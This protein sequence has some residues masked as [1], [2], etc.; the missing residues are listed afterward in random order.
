MT[1]MKTKLRLEGSEGRLVLEDSVPKHLHGEEVN[2]IIKR[3]VTIKFSLIIA[4]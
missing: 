3:S 1:K 4:W 2:E